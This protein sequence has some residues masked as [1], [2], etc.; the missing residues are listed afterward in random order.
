MREGAAAES[1]PA[2]IRVVLTV[3]RIYMD[4]GLAVQRPTLVPPSA[5]ANLPNLGKVVTRKGTR[6]SATKRVARTVS[7][8]Q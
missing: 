3:R 5:L 4:S 8:P 7:T 2:V 6:P 1:L